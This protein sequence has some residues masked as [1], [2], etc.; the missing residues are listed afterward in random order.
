MFNLDS[1]AVFVTG[2]EIKE[3]VSLGVVLHGWSVS[4]PPQ[5]HLVVDMKGAT[6]YP[7]I[8]LPTFDPSV[9]ECSF[10]FNEDIVALLKS[11][12]DQGSRL[13]M[14]KLR[15]KFAML[16][17]E[18]SFRTLRLNV[19]RSADGSPC[20]S[21]LMLSFAGGRRIE[22]FLPHSDSLAEFSLYFT[23]RD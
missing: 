17:F 14:M 4:S 16:A 3:G 6:T 8:E 11:E 21:G 9:L 10:N 13:S 1:N 20:V 12:I 7:R 18:K 5:F 22:T 19:M 2:G 23:P 15:V